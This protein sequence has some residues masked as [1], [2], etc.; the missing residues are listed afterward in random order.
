MFNSKFNTLL[1]VLLIVAIIAILGIIGYFGYSIYN[2]YYINTSAKDVIDNFEQNTGNVVTPKPDDVDTNVTLG[3]GNNGNSIYGNPSGITT[4]YGGYKVVG[5]MSIPAINI[6]YPILAK[7]TVKSLKIALAYLSGPGINEVGNTV[8]QGHNYKNGLFFSNLS[9][10]SNGDKIYIK[11]ASG[12]EITY[13]VYRNFT[14]KATDT[15][16]YNRDTSGKR[17]VTLST[18]TDNDN[19]AR[20]IVFAREI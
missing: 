11:D 1:T 19:S 10:L 2:K 4:E 7:V 18:C 6:K 3:D 17:E 16:F 13:E 5:T 8:I 12:T 20:I 15:T 9:K 14:A